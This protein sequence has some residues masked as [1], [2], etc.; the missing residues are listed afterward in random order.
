MNKSYVAAHFK[1][2]IENIYIIGC[3]KGAILIKGLSDA[4]VVAYRYCIGGMEM[5]IISYRD[6][7]SI[8]DGGRANEPDFPRLHACFCQARSFFDGE[9]LLDSEGDPVS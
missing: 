9:Q 6:R 5:L 7:A 2:R 4:A 3:P 1:L 8:V